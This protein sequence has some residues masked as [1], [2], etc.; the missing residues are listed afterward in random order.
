MS[1][2]LKFM[3][4]VLQRFENTIRLLSNGEDCFELDARC[5]G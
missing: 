4:D 5:F 1:I 2:D 3:E